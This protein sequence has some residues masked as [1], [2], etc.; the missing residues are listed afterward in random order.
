MIACVNNSKETNLFYR[1]SS[2][3]LDTNGLCSLAY[4]LLIFLVLSSLIWME[5]Q[6][7]QQV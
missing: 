1:D 3:L 2:T 7:D 5:Y 4:R 6:I